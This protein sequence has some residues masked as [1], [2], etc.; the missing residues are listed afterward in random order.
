MSRLF[1]FKRGLVHSYW[2]ANSWTFYIGAEKVLSVIWKYLGWLKDV[3]PA[4]M[5]GGLVQ[6]QS[7]L[8]LP[9]PT[10]IVTFILTFVAI[11]VSL[12]K[13]R[14]S[15]NSSFCIKYHIYFVNLILFLIL[16]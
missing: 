2:A 1:P 7:F 5:T 12:F 6:E 10:P 15:L 4:V 11:L 3:K 8:V 9:T 13:L 14:D 16:H